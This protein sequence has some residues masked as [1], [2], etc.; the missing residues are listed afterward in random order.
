MDVDA[1]VHPL[2]ILYDEAEEMVENLPD[3]AIK[4]FESI[5]KYGKLRIESNGR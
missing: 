2:Q 4:E 1:P 3:R 5:L